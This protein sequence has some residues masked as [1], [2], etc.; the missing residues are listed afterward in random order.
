VAS[1]IQIC[2]LPLTDNHQRSP[3]RVM[4]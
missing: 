4:V 2:G 3:F 1:V